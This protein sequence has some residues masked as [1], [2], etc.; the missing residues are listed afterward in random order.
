MGETGGAGIKVILSTDLFVNNNLYLLDPTISMHKFLSTLSCILF[1]LGVSAQSK[2]LFIVNPGKKITEEIAASEIYR[3]PGFRPATIALKDGSST[4]VELNYNSLFG[5]MQFIDPNGDTLSLAD[6]KNIEVIAF[7]KDTFYFDE[8]WIELVYNYGGVKLG[9]K[10]MIELSNREKIGAL[11]TSAA[12]SISTYST[13]ATGQYMKDIVARERLSFTAR[14]S[15]YFGN[16]F[17]SFSKATKKSLLKCF[18][19]HQVELEV[20]LKQNSV[21]FSNEKDLE[22]L[23]MYLQSL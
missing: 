22:R 12:G 21:D 17:N 2:S 10:K 11:E 19:E 1:L 16:R 3:Y 4:R 9:K 14:T 18:A 7:S 23:S 8:G 5:E 15:Y 20:W 13:V 6:E